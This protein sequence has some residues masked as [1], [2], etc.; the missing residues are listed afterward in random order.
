MGKGTRNELE[1]K[2][3]WWI[4]G[5]CLVNKYIEVF[6]SDSKRY[7]CDIQLNGSWEGMFVLEFISST[8]QHVVKHYQDIYPVKLSVYRVRLMD[9]S[10]EV[11]TLSNSSVLEVNQG[12][13]M[14]KSLQGMTYHS[15]PQ[16]VWIW[17]F[18]DYS[19][20]FDQILIQ[21]LELYPM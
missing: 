9:D 18:V 10:A 14:Y 5:Y 4:C 2:Q 15:L 17:I 1:K 12:V 13:R 21:K 11:H 8:N 3:R 20:H 19:Y 7:L 16:V 6:C